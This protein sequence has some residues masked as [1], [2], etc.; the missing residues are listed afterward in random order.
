MMTPPPALRNTGT[1]AWQ[2]RNT[3]LTLT[4]KARSNSSSPI[5][6]IGLLMWVV[7]ALLT[8]MSRPPNAD[9][10]SATAAAKSA[11]LVTSQAIAM[12]LLPMARAAAFAAS[13]LMSA[14]VTRAPSR[15]KVS[16]MHLP[17]P[18]PAPVTRAVL[19]SRRIFLAPSRHDAVFLCA[20]DPAGVA[21]AVDRVEHGRVID[22]AFVG[23]AAGRHRGDLHVADDGEEFFEALEQIAAH[24]LHVIE[25]ELDAHIGRADLGDDVG[26]VLDPAQE[27]IRPVALIDRLDQ[28]RDVG[29]GGVGRGALEVFD[30]NGLRRWAL[31][32]RHRAG[33][34]MD[35]AAAD[36]DHIIERALE[37]CVPIA[38]APRQ[39]GKAEFRALRRVDAELGEAMAL[40][41]GRHRR[42]RD[43]IRKLQLDRGKARRGGGAEA[44]DQRALGEQMT[45]IGGKARHGVS[46]VSGERSASSCPA[47]AATPSA[48]AKRG[49]MGAPSLRGAK[50]R[51]NPASGTPTG[52][53]R[54]ARNDEQSHSRN[55]SVSE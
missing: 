32:R 29:L 20:A 6:S 35:G 13:T 43:V 39:R 27:I 3:P 24:D 4:A 52:L 51:S 31:F 2:P 15:A 44:L 30:E 38:L 26:G 34:A 23:L 55:T 5:S 36:R 14:S 40:E 7:P 19:P 10:V 54:S 49:R 1:T 16:A 53:L 11:F 41:L 47:I 12:A 22:L 8:R 48:P 21:G 46:L 17:M 42:R 9:S 33:H 18:D 25:I 45:E 28:Q 37:G 50:R